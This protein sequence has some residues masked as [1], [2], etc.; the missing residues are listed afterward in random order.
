MKLGIVGLP[1]SG[2]ST[3]FNA[4]MQTGAQAANYPFSTVNPN[5]G[6]VPVPDKRLDDLAA[7]YQPKVVTPAAIEMVD[8][9][10]LVKGASKGEGLG[11]QFLGNIREVDALVHVVRLFEDENVPHVYDT[12]DPK[13]DIETIDLELIFADLELIE[14]RAIRV[15]KVARTDKSFAREAEILAKIIAVLEEGKPARSLKWDDPEDEKLVNSFTLIT[16]KPV[17]YAANISE[18]MVGSDSPLLKELEAFVAAEGTTLFVSCA[19]LEAEIAELSPEEKADFLADLGLQANGLDRLIF[20]GYHL[21]GLISFLTAG[22]KEVRAWTVRANSKA[23]QAAGKIHSDLERGFIRAEVV[24][25][26]DL[27]A[28]GNY[29]SAKE[30]GVVRVEGKEYIVKDGDVMLIRFNV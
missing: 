16:A 1:N 11:N 2:K 21:L 24:A 18:E 15:E 28:A 29:T 9:A 5:V 30:Q 22:P 26:D 10:G 13:R 14:R 7:M 12:I 25:F 17:L 20:A 8:I 27:M 19:K 4:I 3:L 23:P 6:R